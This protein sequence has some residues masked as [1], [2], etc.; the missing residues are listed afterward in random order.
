MNK[1]VRWFLIGEGVLLLYTF[2]YV[3]I[4]ESSLTYTLLSHIISSSP[5]P[6]HF[7][8]HFTFKAGSEYITITPILN[9]TSFGILGIILIYSGITGR[10]NSI[11]RILAGI[12]FISP[13]IVPCLLFGDIASSIAAY[14]ILAVIFI[15][16]GIAGRLNRVNRVV[17][18]IVSI[19]LIV[20][21]I[22]VSAV[23]YHVNWLLL[24]AAAFPGFPFVGGLIIHYY[25]ERTLGSAL[26]FVLAVKPDL[27]LKVKKAL[28]VGNKK[29]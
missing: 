25:F 3:Y 18:G 21:I 11:A 7:F 29:E 16:I 17:S 12:S 8:P 2:L 9:I 19:I 22:A 13:T 6:P 5:P 24:E 1:Y 23:I 15:Y 10:I 27:L 26:G 4:A 14:G 20:A 28:G